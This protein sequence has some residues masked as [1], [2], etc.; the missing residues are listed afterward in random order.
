MVQPILNMDATA[1]DSIA[2]LFEGDEEAIK[3][4][5]NGSISVETETQTKTKKMWW[6][7]S[8]RSN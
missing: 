8:S 3:S 5:C 6:T 7:N 1:I 4:N 2:F